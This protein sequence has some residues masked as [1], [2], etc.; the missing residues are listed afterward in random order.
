MC[1][2]ESAYYDYSKGGYCLGSKRLERDQFQRFTERADK[3]P[4][5][6]PRIRKENY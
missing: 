3:V 4:L 2:R 1:Y 5:N 6:W